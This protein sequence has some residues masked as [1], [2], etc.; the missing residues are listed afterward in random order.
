MK[1]L[2]H[3]GAIV[4]AVVLASSIL[5]TNPV[6]KAAHVQTYGR[7]IA[8]YSFTSI[9]NPADPTFTQLLGIN[10]ANLI[11]GYYGSGADAQHPNKG[12][13]LS[14]PLSFTPENFPNSAQTQVIGINDQNTTGGFYID[15]DGNTHGFVNIGGQFSTVDVPGTTFNQLLGVNNRGEQAGYYQFG[16]DTNVTFVPYIHQTNGLF[17]LLPIPNAQA[18]GI[19]DY[20]MVC[21]FL[22]DAQGSHGYL[23]RSGASYLQIDYPGAASTQILGI[24]NQGQA[25]GSFTNSD[26]NTHGFVYNWYSRTFQQV[27]VPGASSTVVN[28]I[29]RQ[30]RIVG[31]FTDNTNNTVGFVGVPTR[32]H[33]SE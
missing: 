24:N 4:G 6:A 33:G 22:N 25:V 8:S 32:R 10:S 1:A 19:N 12:F 26:K 13:T 27:D 2:Q 16:P 14:L 31:F 11:A 20:D 9:S 30:G 23:W 21:G 3:V 5:G 15:M 28:G 18:T 7:D 17:L 29:N